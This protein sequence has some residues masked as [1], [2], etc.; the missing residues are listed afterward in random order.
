MRC[1]SATARERS[2]S[3]KLSSELVSAWRNQRE[4]E[5]SRCSIRSARRRPMM[6]KRRTKPVEIARRA[7]PY[8]R[9]GSRVSQSRLAVTSTA[10]SPIPRNSRKTRIPASPASLNRT[11]A[12]TKSRPPRLP[13]RNGSQSGRRPKSVAKSRRLQ[14]TTAV[15]ASENRFTDALTAV[16]ACSL[17]LFATDFGLRPDWLPFRLGS[18]GGL[19]FVYACV[20]LSDAGDAGMR[21]LR[22]FLGIGLRAVLVTASLL[23]LTREPSLEYGLALL[24][25]STGFVL[26]FTIMG[27]LRALRIE[28]RD[29][30]FSRWF[31]HADTSSLESFVESLRSLAVAEQHLIL[32][33]RYLDGYEE[34][35]IVGDFDAFFAAPFHCY[36]RDGRYVSPMQSD[37]RR[38]LSAPRNPLFR[39]HGAG[40]FFT[41][42][43]G[44]RA[45]GR[46]VA[47]V[48][49][50][51]NRL[52]GLKRSYFGFFDC[53][54]DPEVAGRL[55]G[56]AE[57]WGRRQ[58]CDEIAGNFHLTAV[59]QAGV[60]TG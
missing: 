57:D 48:H 24:A 20:R 51:S 36:G 58:G 30:S 46:V 27:R 42:R 21:V 11:Q 31:L 56:A 47:H 16:V 8:S 41:V 28:Q 26:L 13:R 35:P 25:I 29:T 2:D 10:R 52:Y 53:A 40:T 17:L 43:Q 37:L 39:E 45:V 12:Y 3:T 44:G 6:V 18:L 7:S 50:A 14:A 33:G 49:R 1:C 15:R 59:Q 22:E 4:N 38:F 9:L 5:V 34:A 60:L 23:W 32:H 54:D 55:L 19:L